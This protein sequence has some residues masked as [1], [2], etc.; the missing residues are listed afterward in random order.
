MGDVVINVKNQ[1]ICKECWDY[2]K[3]IILF[4]IKEIE[5]THHEGHICCERCDSFDTHYSPRQ[6]LAQVRRKRKQ[7]RKKEIEAHEI[8]SFLHEYNNRDK[9]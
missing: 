4:D 2:D 9:T 5:S 6:A 1:Y 7:L 8:N 3:T